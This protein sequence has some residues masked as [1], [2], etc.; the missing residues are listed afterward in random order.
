MGRKIQPTSNGETAA[1]SETS[2]SD[3]AIP[4]GGVFE[5]G[6]KATVLP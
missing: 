5:L 4:D 6:L 1:I 2:L 3:I